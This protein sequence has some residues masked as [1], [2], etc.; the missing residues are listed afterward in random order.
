MAKKWIQKAIKHKGALKQQ[1]GVKSV[2]KGTLNQV[3]ARLHKKAEK[4]KLSP[5]ERALSRRVT[6]AKT[7]M[8]LHKGGK[9]S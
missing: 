1:L 7:L 9:K 4:G 6:L 2:T 5:S 8:N 3:S